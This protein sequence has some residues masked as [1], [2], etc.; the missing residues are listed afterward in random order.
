MQCSCCT[1]VHEEAPAAHG[2]QND[3]RRLPRHGVRSMHLSHGHNMS[4]GNRGTKQFSL[5]LVGNIKAQ[6][7]L[8]R[9][10]AC[11]C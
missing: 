10:A 8:S 4:T 5:N 11:G 3:Y 6:L 2:W 1:L 7:L 9:L